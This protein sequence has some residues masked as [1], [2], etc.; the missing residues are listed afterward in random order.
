ME[1]ESP[2]DGT[3]VLITN[4]EIGGKAGREGCGKGEGG[5]ALSGR[6]LT[7]LRVQNEPLR[8]NGLGSGGASLSRCFPLASD[9][10]RFKG[11]N[12]RPRVLLR[13]R[14]VDEEGSSCTTE[15]SL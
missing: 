2:G 10:I 12:E 8:V 14:G 1:T 7:L 4:G 6:E 5:A 9:D 15:G 11:P 13:S 3:G